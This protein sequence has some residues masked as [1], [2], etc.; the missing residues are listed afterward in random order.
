MQRSSSNAN[1]AFC[2]RTS[3]THRSS[4]TGGGPSADF[5]LA[6]GRETRAFT[7]RGSVTATYLGRSNLYNPVDGYTTAVAAYWTP[8]LGIQTQTRLTNR[9]SLN[10]DGSYTF[11]GTPA[12]SNNYT[13]VPHTADL[14]DYQTISTAL[15]YQFVPNRLVGS[16]VYSHTFYDQTNYIFPSDPTLDSSRA[17]SQNSLGVALRYAF[18]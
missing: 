10:V 12:E 11:N 18:R 7:I 4:V 8:S 1:R 13:G 9:L 6:I 17:R 16:I 5:G 15:N 3:S 14:G 2:R